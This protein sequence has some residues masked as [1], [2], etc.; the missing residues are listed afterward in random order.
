MSKGSKK[1]LKKWASMGIRHKLTV[2]LVLFAVFVLA[3]I[4]LLQIKL[5]SYFYEREKFAELEEA[6]VEICDNMGDADFDKQLDEIAQKHGICIRVFVIVNKQAKEV[7]D[8]DVGMTCMIHHLNQSLL[9]SLH[10]NAALNDGSYDKRMEL[11]NSMEGDTTS[12]VYLPGLHRPDDT[13]NAICVRIM[14][15][16]GQ[17]YFVLLDSELSP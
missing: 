10:R 6:Y 11:N 17:E 8:A 15:Y 13:V 3:A 16:E 9:F 7:A 1:G 12:G 5:L 4:W 2:A 14:Q